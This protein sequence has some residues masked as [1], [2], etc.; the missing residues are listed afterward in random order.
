LEAIADSI[1]TGATILSGINLD[2]LAKVVCADTT[3]AV[4][5]ST[6][7][8]DDT[9][10]AN[11][12]D[13]GGVVANYDRRNHSLVAI[14][15]DT[16][17]LIAD[18]VYQERCIEKVAT[19]NND[20]LFDVTGEII[21]TSLIGIVTTTA[22]G[23][24]QNRIKIGLD[25][26]DL[27]DNDFS[28]EVDTVSDPV[29]TRYVFSAANP[30]VLT[31]LANGAAGSSQPMWPWICRPGVIEQFMNGGDAG[32]TGQINWYLTYRPLSSDGVVVASA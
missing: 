19:S 24:V 13:D 14:G 8:A 30:A 5:M 10:L 32:T 23:A 7:I 25:A 2:H 12:L 20:D 29:G 17:A 11:I 16:D 21:I 28:T 6:E 3:D 15:D 1:L 31:P 26:T 22:I 9:I 4:D 18:L 27:F